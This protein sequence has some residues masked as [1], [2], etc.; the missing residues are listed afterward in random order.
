MPLTGPCRTVPS[1]PPAPPSPSQAPVELSPLMLLP[2]HGFIPLPLLLY[3]TMLMPVVP[4]LFL[5][6]LFPG[7]ITLPGPC[8]ILAPPR[9]LHPPMLMSPPMLL[10]HPRLLHPPRLLSPPRLL[11]HPRLLSSCPLT[12]PECFPWPPRLFH[13][14]GRI[15]S[16]PTPRSLP[17]GSCQAVHSHS[18]APVPSQFISPM[19]SCSILDSCPKAPAPHRLLPPA[20]Q[21]H[22]PRP[23]H[24][25]WSLPRA[26]FMH[27][28]GPCKA[29]SSHSQAPAFVPLPGYFLQSPPCSCPLPV[30]V[31]APP[32]LLLLPS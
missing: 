9:S 2:Q 24:P 27:L 6:M 30:Q 14:L 22:P 12:P 15:L 1:Q 3:P 10:S 23:P 8:T 17:P 11:R 25:P 13:A 20:R 4:S 28:P 7:Q 31:P 21:L 18:Q 32:R 29:V 19:G 26:I 5:S 16:L